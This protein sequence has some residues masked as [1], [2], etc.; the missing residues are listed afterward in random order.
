[1][2]NFFPLTTLINDRYLYLPCVPMLVMTAFAVK[3]LAARCQHFTARLGGR[4]L[5]FGLASGTGIAAV[6]I[7]TSMGS[8]AQAKIWQ[9]PLTLWS[10]TMRHV[11]QLAVVRI[12]WA[13]T[14]HD[15]G[16]TLEARRVLE[17]ALAECEMDAHDRR[18]I[19]EKLAEWGNL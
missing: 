14:L 12:Q 13:I 2:L 16:R 3:W 5:P 7:A 11:P 6:I 19:E 1:M 17:S 8:A 15:A 10:D 9:D 4:S 18:R